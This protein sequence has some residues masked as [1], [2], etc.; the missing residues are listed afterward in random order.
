VSAGM[1]LLLLLL[2][3]RQVAQLCKEE[4]PA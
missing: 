3:D 4:P 1:L 2:L